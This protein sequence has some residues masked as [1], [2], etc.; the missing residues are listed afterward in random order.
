VDTQAQLSKKIVRK[1]KREKRGKN[2]QERKLSSTITK[3]PQVDW[4]IIANVHMA[5]FILSPIMADRDL[6]NLCLTVF[7]GVVSGDQLLGKVKVF[8]CLFDTQETRMEALYIVPRNLRKIGE[9]F[10]LTCPVRHSC[11]NFLLLLHTMT[12]KKSE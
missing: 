12:S 9:L 10:G 6:E 8:S 7:E 4:V 1:E 3:C 5:D 2:K 11:D